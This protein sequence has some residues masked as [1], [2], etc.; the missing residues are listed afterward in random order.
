M[1]EDITIKPLLALRGMMVLPGMIINL[2]IG[3]DKSMNAVETVMNNDRMI[4]LVTQKD[5][6]VTDITAD[7][8]YK[9]GV[10]AEVKQELR[11]PNGALRIL[12]EG[13]ERVEIIEVRDADQPKSY[14]TG[15]ARIIRREHKEDAETAALRRLLIE[16][17]EQ[18]ILLTKKSMPKC[19]RLS[20]P[21]LTAAGWPI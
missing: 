11:L 16:A 19:C 12:V 4:L 3:R 14:F 13:L 1:A 8:L 21:S 5:A 10:L 6:S 9:F 2:D 15:E 20:I 17:F 18:W 7:D